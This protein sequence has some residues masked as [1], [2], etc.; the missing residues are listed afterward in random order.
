MLETVIEIEWSLGILLGVLLVVVAVHHRAFRDHPFFFAFFTL[1]LFW[2]LVVWVFRETLFNVRIFTAKELLI[3][4]FSVGLAFVQA[5]HVLRPYPGIWRSIRT[6]LVILLLISL[7]YCFYIPGFLTHSDQLWEK[8]NLQFHPR[9][10]STAAMLF[11]IIAMAVHFYNLRVR[12][13]DKII[14]LGFLVHLGPNAL[15]F[16][17]LQHFMESVTVGHVVNMFYL[18]FYSL[19]ECLWIGIYLPNH[20]VLDPAVDRHI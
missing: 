10:S 4:I 16:F 12:R 18:G 15:G 20:D 1:N 11:L 17:F 19:A 9:L 3:D 8:L 6:F 13:T 7:A 5:N 14:I 2:G